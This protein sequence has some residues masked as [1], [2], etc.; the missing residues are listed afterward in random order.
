VTLKVIHRLQAF[1]NAIRR[2]VVQ[3]FK[4]F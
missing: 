3:H 4:Q 1:A 2:T